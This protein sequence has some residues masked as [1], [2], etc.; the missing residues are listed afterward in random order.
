MGKPIF[1]CESWFR[2]KKIAQ[3]PLA[4]DLARKKHLVGEPYVALLGSSTQPSCFVEMILNKGMVGVGFLDV[5]LR[6]Y[7]T[8]QFQRIDADRLFLT[9]ATYRTFEGDQDKATSAESYIFRQ[10]GN[11]IIRRKSKDGLG[12]E[13]S[14]STFDPVGNYERTPVFGDY[15]GVTR[16]ER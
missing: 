6:E 14:A 7:L 5:L 8:Y 1:Y 15:T 9:M 2:F 12:V 11:L 3:E 16:V 10:D 13:E 4:E